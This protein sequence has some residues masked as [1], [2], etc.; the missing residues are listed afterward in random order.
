VGELGGPLGRPRVGVPRTYFHD[1]ID[2]GV[3][4]KFNDFVNRL[5][6]LG[7]EVNEVELDG[8]EEAFQIW[9]PIRKAEATAFHLKWLDSHPE[10]YGDDARRL[11]NEGR[12][13]TGVEYVS[14]QNAR[15]P[16]MERFMTSMRNIDFIVVP[17][18]SIPAPPIGRSSV[19]AGSKEVNVRTALL[20]FTVPFN[21]VGFPAISVPAGASEG[22]PVGI[23]MVAKPFDESVLLR[24][25]NAFEIRFGPFPAPP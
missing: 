10:M 13:V 2:P 24:V 15:P 21:V 4:A 12:Q 23:Q 18:T 1:P 9:L 16:L 25:V 20:R 19:M 14:A 11:L 3:E 17:T 8:V 6:E 5:T 22:L 7:C